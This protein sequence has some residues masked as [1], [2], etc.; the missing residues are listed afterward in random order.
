MAG[1]PQWTRRH[2]VARV[3]E[4]TA[5]G[6]SASQIARRLDVS[7]RTIHRYRARIRATQ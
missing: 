3:K 4:L 5:H 2:R 7:T 6:A 1:I